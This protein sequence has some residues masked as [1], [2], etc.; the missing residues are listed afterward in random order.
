MADDEEPALP[1]HAARRW[2]MNERRL[3]DEAVERLRSLDETRDMRAVTIE[4]AVLAAQSNRELGTATIVAA[5]SV[6]AGIDA[7]DTAGSALGTRLDALTEATK[8]STKSLTRWTKVMA[9]AT[10]ALAFFAVVQI[11]VAVAGLFSPPAIVQPQ[12]ITVPKP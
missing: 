11:A 3:T 12:V 5:E 1:G 9:W 8:A 2:H 10:I 6:S 7:L 4:A